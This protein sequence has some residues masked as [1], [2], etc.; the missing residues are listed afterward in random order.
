LKKTI[1]SI[2]KQAFKDF[3]VWIIDGDSNKE[4]QDLLKSLEVP[5]FYQ[6]EK[7][8]G[9]YDAMNK[10]I[11]LSKGEWLYFLGAGDLLHNE[12]VLST[13]FEKSIVDTSRIIAGKII[14]EGATN[15]FVYSKKK[16]IKNPFWSFSM[17]IRNGLHHQ[18]TFYKRELFSDIKYDLEFKTLSDYW[19]NLSL[20]KQKEPCKIIDVLIAKC[21]S[22]GI[23]KSGNWI[24]Y[25]EEANLKKT[26]TST[27]FAPL[28]YIIAFSKYVSRKIVND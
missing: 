18:G 3:E 9:I 4:T 28:F 21:N 13:I 23:S 20:Y 19:F 12:T 15:P 25:K 22:D 27:L 7:D 11:Y 24:I 26:L 5:F 2:K 1:D 16:R 10:G 8:N 17:W 6:S 14:Y